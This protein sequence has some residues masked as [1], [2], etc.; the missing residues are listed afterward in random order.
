MPSTRPIYLK[1][2]GDIGKLVR[3]RRRELGMTQDEFAGLA[4]VG[5]RFLV[6]LEKGKPTLQIDRVL[7]VLQACGYDLYG[8]RR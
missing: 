2:A 1:T 8:H 5:R 7:S 3:E 6:E 4:N